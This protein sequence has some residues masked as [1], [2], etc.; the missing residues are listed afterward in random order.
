MKEPR[1]RFLFLLYLS[2]ERILLLLVSITL[3]SLVSCEEYSTSSPSIYFDELSPENTGIHFSNTI[4]E[5]DTL[6]YF[7][8]PFLYLGGGVSVGDINNDGLS[9]IYFT[10]NLVPNKLYLNKGNNTFEDISETANV[11]GDKRWYTGSTMADVNND[12]F[13]DI[14][15]GASEVF[16]N[17]GNQLFINNGDNTFTE[18]AEAF[19]IADKSTTIQSTFF[20]YDNDGFLDLFVANYPIVK[21]SM[22]NRY[23]K[24][25]MDE[26]R[27][28]I[29][30]NGLTFS[31]ESVV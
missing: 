18:K 21:V 14:Y 16:G 4:I 3:L 2:M 27:I 12:G 7:K 24:E 26:N 10:G 17:S 11:S 29:L 22:G 19:G 9:D 31:S 23:Y 28:N 5:S 1:E 20:D 13:L 6:N 8:F 15:V 25:K 30:Y